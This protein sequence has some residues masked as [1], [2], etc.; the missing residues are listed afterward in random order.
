M[1]DKDTTKSTFIQLFEPILSEKIFV[2]LKNLEADK[3]VKKLR[4]TQLLELIALAQLEQQRGLRD[5]GNSL[6][7]E[8]LS[9]A[10]H[11]PQSVLRKYLA[12]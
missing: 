9:K 5:I 6:N 11:P 12:D 4:T 1:Q 2:P 10:I 7:N 3:Y 8:E